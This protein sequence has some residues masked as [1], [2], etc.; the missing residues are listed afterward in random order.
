V[1]YS[2]RFSAGTSDQSLSRLMTG[3][4][5]WFWSL[6]T[7]AVLGG[8]KTAKAERSLLLTVPHTNLSEVTRVVLVNVG[9]VVVLTT[10]HTA[11]SG[12]LPVLSDTSVSGGNVTA[13]LAGVGQSAWWLVGRP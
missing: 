10:S 5:N 3:F 1:R 8:C 9:P 13:V 12:M 2:S 4:Q 11:T 6:W 7:G